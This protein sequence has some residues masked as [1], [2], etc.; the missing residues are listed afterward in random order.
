[1]QSFSSSNAFYDFNSLIVAIIKEE[2]VFEQVRTQSRFFLFLAM[3]IV[4][5]VSLK[6]KFYLKH[7]GNRRAIFFIYIP[8][9]LV[10]IES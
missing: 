10:F 3:N 1:M 7:A 9:L 2:V 4:Q 6:K 5:T 8:V